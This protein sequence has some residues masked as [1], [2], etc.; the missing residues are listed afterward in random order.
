MRGQHEPASQGRNAVMD[1]EMRCD[2]SALATSDRER[3]D[4]KAVEPPRLCP[5]QAEEDKGGA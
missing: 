4:N 5:G 3:E 1:F 2:Q